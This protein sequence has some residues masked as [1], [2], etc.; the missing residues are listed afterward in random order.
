MLIQSGFTRMEC[1]NIW[2]GQKMTIF[3]QHTRQAKKSEE[4]KVIKELEAVV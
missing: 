2:A 1:G 3:S 4:K